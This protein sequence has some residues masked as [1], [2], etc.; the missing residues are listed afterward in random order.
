MRLANASIFL[1]SIA[2]AVTA[3]GV[4]WAGPDPAQAQVA[5]G[6]LLFFDPVLSGSR[7]L[8]CAHCHHPDLGMADGRAR[9][10]GRGGAGFGPARQGGVTL[11][12]HTPSLWNVG[13]SDSLFWDGRAT[14]LEAQARDVLVHPEEMAA[15]PERLLVDLAAI[16]E[17]QERFAQA[18][19]ESQEGAAV[20]VENVTLALAS[21]ERSL[22]ADDTRLDRYLAGDLEALSPAARRG[23]KLFGSPMTRCS[24]CHA[25]PDFR[26]AEFKVTGLPDVP[27][28]APDFGRGAWVEQ[29][30]LRGAFKVPGLRNVARTA[31]Y[32]HDGSLSSLEEVIDFYASGKGRERLAEGMFVDDFIR[33][34]EINAEDRADL[35]AFLNSLTDESR[36]PRIP[37]RVPSG[38]PVVKP[39]T[40]PTDR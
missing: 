3:I 34:F 8:S 32:M 11:R 30:M 25:P 31:P 2:L 5:L 40:P 10:M 38:L 18:F 17:Y 16:E 35:V 27:G 36:R 9:A 15:D 28:E 29:P 19:P 7:E 33:S 21:F 4:T 1:T 20:S 37:M 23:W 12:R 39:V 24:E 22:R 13:D 26:V 14:S 6:R